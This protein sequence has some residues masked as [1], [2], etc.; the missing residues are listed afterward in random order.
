VHAI[1]GQFAACLNVEIGV[2]D[3]FK[4]MNPRSV[5]KVEDLDGVIMLGEKFAENVGGA[6]SPAASLPSESTLH[7]T[8]RRRI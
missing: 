2:A 1:G 4:V 8:S 6:S 5:D 7:T 3:I